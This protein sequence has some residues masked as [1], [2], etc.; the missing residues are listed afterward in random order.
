MS[1]KLEGKV[2]V[3]T[4]GGGGIGRWI[5]LGLAEEGAKVVVND[6]AKSPEGVSAADKVVQEVKQANGVA[7]ANYDSVATMSGGE[8]IAKAAVDN[9]GRID[10]LINAA[11]NF[12]RVPFFE[13][14]E[15]Q[16]DSIIAVHLKGL[17]S[18]SRAAA[19]YMVQQ[20]TGG[21][22]INFS[23]RAFLGGTNNIA[24]GAGKSGVIGFTMMVAKELAPY[25]ITVNAI[26]PGAMTALFPGERK[27]SNDGIP[28]TRRPQPEFVAPI[29]IYLS[30]DLAQ[31]ITGRFFYAA[32]S[33]ICV[34]GE[35]FKLGATSS[36]TRKP[37]GAKWTVDE[38]AE[39]VPPLAG[40]VP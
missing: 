8:N 36:F 23:S 33:D 5:V 19:K 10:I 17:F 31:K 26:L 20:K 16:W 29:F 1:G 2:A 12:V 11:G 34:Y 27:P 28:L 21:R 40:L 6:I 15:A 9:F 35:P 37:G 4:G 7:V 39:I 24:Y 22:I 30:T 14:T 13:L 32:G 25:N 3:V 18:C 38:L